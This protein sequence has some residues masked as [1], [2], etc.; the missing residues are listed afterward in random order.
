MELEVL[1]TVDPP[2]RRCRFGHFG[3]LERAGLHFHRLRPLE[4]TRAGLPPLPGD[5]GV[6]LRE[7]G[8]RKFDPPVV[9]HEDS[10]IVANFAQ[11]HLDRAAVGARPR[12]LQSLVGSHR[13]RLAEGREQGKEDAG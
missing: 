7:A 10:G 6:L 9:H 2:A 12:A 3:N 4:R 5:R 13:R 11:L 8:E 1:G